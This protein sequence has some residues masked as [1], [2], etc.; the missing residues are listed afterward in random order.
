MIKLTHKIRYL[1]LGTIVG[2]GGLLSLSVFGNNTNTL[3]LEK[4]SEFTQVFSH[5][6]RSYVDDV[7]DQALID[8]AIDG[9]L[10]KLDPHSALL[11]PKAYK[12]LQV[13]TRGEFGGLGIVISLSEEGY[14]RVVSPIDDTPAFRAGVLAGDLIVKLDD[15]QVKGLSLDEAMGIMR[16]KVGD[17]IT[18]TILR[19]GE[20]NLITKEIVRD[21]IKIQSVR[22]RLVDNEYGYL[23]ISKF[24]ANTAQQLNTHIDR[25]L[26]QQPNI[27]GLVLDLRNNPGGLLNAAVDVSSAFMDGG[28]VVYTRGRI[29]GSNKKYN[30]QK[31]E[32][33]PN[34][35]VVVLINEGSASASEI[36]AGALQ[37]TSR[38]L[39]MGRTSFGKGSVQSVLQLKNSKS[40]LKLTTAKYY[41]PKGRSIQATGIIPDIEIPRMKIELLK[42][43]VRLKEKNLPRHLENEQTNS[44]AK[45]TTTVSST[46]T[47]TVAR[48]KKVATE[49]TKG[50]V[51]KDYE[52][53]MALNTLKGFSFR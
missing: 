23:R 22:S 42:G 4:I 26:N 36:V 52:L 30:A 27:K 37:D 48:L 43:D 44:K 16:G 33:L 21:T 39:V 28:L 46:P 49:S 3:F 25:I 53:Y 12:K 17:K 29:P 20:K 51:K 32:K 47:S 31:G 24:Q 14:V 8:D 19:E 11:R 10:Q 35:P 34:I 2:A 18:I 15:K 1:C 45:T 5:V 6:K 7:D 40:G 41:T 13:S 50:L 9:M 38:A